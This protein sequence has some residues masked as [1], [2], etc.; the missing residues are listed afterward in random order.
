MDL[1]TTLALLL[2]VFEVAHLRWLTDSLLL[3]LLITWKL[4]RM[5]HVMNDTPNV[6]LP[7]DSHAES[8][9]RETNDR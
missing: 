4:A 2:G 5:Q 1:V 7:D 6:S 9:A 3:R 8:K